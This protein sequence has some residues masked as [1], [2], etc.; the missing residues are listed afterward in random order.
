[1]SIGKDGTMEEVRFNLRLPAFLHEKIVRR[2]KANGRSMN[3]EI[4]FMLHSLTAV[5]D[6]AVL[7]RLNEDARS[8][9]RELEASKEMVA[10]L[11]ERLT[12]IQ[13]VIEEIRAKRAA[14]A[15]SDVD[16]STFF[17]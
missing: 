1:M 11:S 14:Q 12:A 2:A 4:I 5:P 10:V 13:G 16:I 7:E 9:E 6:E 8:V 3:S 15:D 17:K